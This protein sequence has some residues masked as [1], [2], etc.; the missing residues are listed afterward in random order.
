[1]N[2]KFSVQLCNPLGVKLIYWG[3]LAQQW[4]RLVMIHP[5][6]IACS[7]FELSPLF[8]QLFP[9]HPFLTAKGWGLLKFQLLPCIFIAWFWF[10]CWFFLTLQ[11]PKNWCICFS[12]VVHSD[13]P[14][15]SWEVPEDGNTQLAR[16]GQIWHH[17]PMLLGGLH[18]SS[19]NAEINGPAEIP[20]PK[21]RARAVTLGEGG[22]KPYE[23]CATGASLSSFYF[24][25]LLLLLFF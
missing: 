24:L 21:V 5:Q 20:A 1:M 19:G 16:H 10:C 12:L 22:K 11:A 25:S 17:V 2:G 18:C 14:A 9:S 6:H 23:L 7:A 3:Y 8:P 15:F 13:E 4:E